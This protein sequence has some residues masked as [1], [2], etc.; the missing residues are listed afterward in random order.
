MKSTA[1]PYT[2]PPWAA[3][4]GL[5]PERKL[6]LALR[7]T[8]IEKW[9]PPGLSGSLELWIKRD[10]LTGMT[11]SGNKVR[12]LEFLLADAVEK[13]CDTIITCGGVQSTH[14]RA[15]AVAAREVGI[16]SYLLLRTP[17]TR[18]D[19]G[20][21]GNLLIDRLV[22]AQLRLITPAQYR[23]RASLMQALADELRGRGRK[24]YV[25]PE[26]GSNGLGS[27]GYLD[28]VGEMALQIEASGQAFT[29]IVF[30][31]GSGGTAAGLSLGVQLSG[32]SMRVHAVN[33]CDDADYFHGRV[34]E[35]FAE[36]GCSSRSEDVLDVIDGYVGR[37]Y[38]LSRPEELECIRDVA[39]RTG[40]ILDPVY[41]GKAFFGLKNEWAGNPDRFR[42]R[43]VLFLHTGGLFGFYDK[44]DEIET[45]FDK[46]DV[47]DYG[48]GRPAANVETRSR[49]D[50]EG[51]KGL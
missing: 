16:D 35:I 22:H 30:A 32:L 46:E 40:I 31:C 36:L 8:P 19:P 44:L 41:S 38:A 45:L 14:G 49:Q 11:L 39:G 42:G 13:G 24:P 6:S 23:Q 20:L 51:R 43:R 47:K 10:D 15:T 33:V 17:H 37:G 28:A 48:R 9:D 26:G 50:G 3:A 4:L 5:V 21:D 7:P 29:D 18:V 2:P 27:W 25:I 12:K 34:N 1:H